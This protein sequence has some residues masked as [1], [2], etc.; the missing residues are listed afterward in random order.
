MYRVKK[1]KS[2]KDRDCLDSINWNI[3]SLNEDRT[4]SLLVICGLMVELHLMNSI[5]NSL[6]LLAASIVNLI[7]SMLLVS[8]LLSFLNVQNGDVS[9]IVKLNFLR[10]SLADINNQLDKLSNET[11]INYIIS[12]SDKT[13][14]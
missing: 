10:M 11:C 6:K 12:F 13:V 2:E 8:K 5:L 3:L 4:E 9:R 7:S 1:A 14:S